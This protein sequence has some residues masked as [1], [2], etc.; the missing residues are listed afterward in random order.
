MK[1]DLMNDAMNYTIQNNKVLEPR[2][3]AKFIKL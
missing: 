2:A 3:I 1:N